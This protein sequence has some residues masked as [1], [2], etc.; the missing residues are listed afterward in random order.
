MTEL[1]QTTVEASQKTKLQEFREEAWETVRFL[2]IA[3]LVVVPIR[4][5]VAQPFIVSGASMD[6]TFANGQYLIVDELSYN[7]GNPAR[8]DVAIFKYPRN[9]KQYFIKRVIGLPGETVVD[10]QGQISIKDKGGKITLTM[11]EPYVKYPKNDSV[12]HTLK[13]GEYFM[14]GDNRAGSFDSRS[15]GPV[16]RNLIVGK[17]F[18]RLFPFNTVDILPGQFK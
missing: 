7:L 11:N 16:P 5:F 6:P 2:F 1:E 13:D 12:E 3:L 4:I 10:D 8:G 14:M 17:P 15:W 9:Q 18:L